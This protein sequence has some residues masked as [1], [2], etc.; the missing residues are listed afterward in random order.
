MAL[1][2]RMMSEP[3]LISSLLK[4]AERHSGETEIVSKR[5]EG[6]LHRSNWREVALRSRQLAQAFARLGLAAGDRVGTLAWNGYR[7]LEIYYGASGSG[8]VCHTINPRL[9]PE[10]IVWIANDAS[11]RVLCFDATFLPLVEKIAPLLK[12]VQ[13]FVLMTDQAHMPATTSIPKQL[14]FDE[15]LT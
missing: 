1:M 11:D 9:F 6:D 10:Q 14:C 3:L 7:H 4:H 2:G 15:L 5:V 13:H 8:L 12:T